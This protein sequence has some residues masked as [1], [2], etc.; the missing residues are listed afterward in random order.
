MSL[1]FLD[2]FGEFLLALGDETGN[3][4]EGREGGRAIPVASFT[5]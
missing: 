2:V 3:L 4:C 5:F 1:H